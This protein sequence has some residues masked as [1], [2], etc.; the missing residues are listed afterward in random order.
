MPSTTLDR[1]HPDATIRSILQQ[2]DR[3]LHEV[4]TYTDAPD[5]DPLTAAELMG[6]F[7]QSYQTLG[8]HQFTDLLLS[9]EELRHCP[10]DPEETV[11]VED[12]PA[13]DPPNGQPAE[14]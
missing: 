8:Y 9:M 6:R 5:F 13:I 1:E 14:L 4:I 3:E 12:G 11:P 7:G 2:I 10:P